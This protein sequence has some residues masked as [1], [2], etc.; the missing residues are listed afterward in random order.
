[1][2]AICLNNWIYLKEPYQNISNVLQDDLNRIL[3]LTVPFCLS[4]VLFVWNS[5][6]LFVCVVVFLWKRW[7]VPL[8]HVSYVNFDFYV[9]GL[10]Q[11]I[12]IHMVQ[13]PTW[14]NDIK[15]KHNVQW[16]LTMQKKKHYFHHEMHFNELTSSWWVMQMNKC[17]N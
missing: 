17:Y 3:I 12:M 10:E 2:V 14:V 7:P 1:M 16:L 6:F 11:W 9:Q 5:L 4:L 15:V 8:K 13:K